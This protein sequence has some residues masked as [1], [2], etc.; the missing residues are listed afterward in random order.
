MCQLLAHT[1]IINALPVLSMAIK[2]NRYRY[3][4]NGYQSVDKSF[5]H[6]SR[7]DSRRLNSPWIKLPPEL[8]QFGRPSGL[9]ESKLQP[10]FSLP[11]L[12]SFTDCELHVLGQPKFHAWLV[13][14]SKVDWGTGWVIHFA[15]WVCI[16]SIIF[17]SA[18]LHSSPVHRSPPT[19]FLGGFTA[20]V[21]PAQLVG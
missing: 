18:T 17:S 11:L 15:S 20:L 3:A 12:I 19:T 9:F 10:S 7:S 2:I 16:S 1:L 4:G 8:L 6:I 5:R 21:I 13:S 14:A